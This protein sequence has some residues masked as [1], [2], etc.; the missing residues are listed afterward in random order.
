MP[1]DNN[2]DAERN[3]L[4]IGGTAS[5]RELHSRSMASS[6]VPPFTYFMWMFFIVYVSLVVGGITQPVFALFVSN[7]TSAVFFSFETCRVVN[8]DMFDAFRQR[9]EMPY[10]TFQAA[11]IF[12][13]CVPMLTTQVT[14]WYAGYQQRLDMLWIWCAAISSISFHLTWAMFAGGFE[15]S[16][17][18]VPNLQQ[19]E[20][21]RRRTWTILWTMAMF[22]HLLETLVAQL[23][24][25]PITDISLLSFG[26]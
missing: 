17:L 13:H 24:C 8:P 25:R 18:Y 20:K 4:G 2:S 14:R 1:N 26:L 16:H 3:F 7:L 10:Y 12:M 5:V 9:C 6:R 19:N 23:R 22:G 11:D 21:I 15:L